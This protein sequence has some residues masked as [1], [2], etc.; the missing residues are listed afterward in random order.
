MT[1]AHHRERMRRQRLEVAGLP[2]PSRELLRPGDMIADYLDHPA[3]TV[4]AQNE[5]EL[6]AAKTPAQLHAVIHVVPHFAFGRLEIGWD[7]A[8]RTPQ[9]GLVWGIENRKIDRHE[10][11]FVRID[12]QRV[13]RFGAVE[14][15]A[16]LRHDRRWPRVS[17]VNVQPY[18]TLAAD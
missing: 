3:P 12:H 4:R 15:P 13:C 6:E 1:E 17:G 2:D 14:Q 9:Q 10:H 5:P 7:E 18:A 16:Q 11:P 8:E